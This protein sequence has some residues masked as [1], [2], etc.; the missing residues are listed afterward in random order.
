[1][2]FSISVVRSRIDRKAQRVSGCSGRRFTGLPVAAG[3]H[4]SV[5][6]PSAIA[7]R[8]AQE[9]SKVYMCR[10]DAE[11]YAQDD[12]PCMQLGCAAGRRDARIPPSVP[13]V[14]GYE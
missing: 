8:R 7:L 3:L 2:G 5:F 4:S 14:H 12:Y 6:A 10:V 9:I 1:M 11:L 13:I